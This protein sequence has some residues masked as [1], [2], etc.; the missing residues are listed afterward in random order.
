MFLDF[1]E[2]QTC[3]GAWCQN[4]WMVVGVERQALELATGECPQS[5]ELRFDLIEQR[6]VDVEA[7]EPGQFGIAPVA[8]DTPAVWDRMLVDGPIHHPLPG[9]LS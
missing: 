1:V 7:Q 8:I 9:G 3:P 6:A 4:G 5:V 2:R